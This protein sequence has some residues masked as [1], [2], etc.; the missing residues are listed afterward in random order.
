ME[1]RDIVKCIIFSVL[2]CGIYS[3][4]WFIVMT[5]D[6]ARFSNDKSLSGGMAFLL[7]LVT[8]GIYQI[9]WSYLM[10]KKIYEVSEKRN[11]KL[12]DNSILYLVLQIFGFGIINYCLI[13]YDLN[14]L[15][16][17]EV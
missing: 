13:Q 9:Y 6:V 3:I 8:C 11:L 12:A 1:K 2:T 14:K 5:D 15:T 10:G 4:Y 17:Y 16:D 7:S